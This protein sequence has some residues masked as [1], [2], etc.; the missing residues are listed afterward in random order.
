MRGAG[1]GVM[2]A[3]RGLRQGT[4]IARPSDSQAASSL[5]LAS[6][7]PE[8]R[9]ENGLGEPAGPGLLRFSRSGDV[10][11]AHR[12][13]IQELVEQSGTLGNRENIAGEMEHGFSESPAQIE[14]SPRPPKQ[15]V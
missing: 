14:R 3:L 9:V 10:E 1:G 6:G 7:K 5:L 11:E 2:H 4:Q 8:S 12:M 15:P 13:L